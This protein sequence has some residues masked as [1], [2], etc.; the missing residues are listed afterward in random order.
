[1]VFEVAYSI[2]LMWLVSTATLDHMGVV[3]TGAAF[4]CVRV[5]IAADMYDQGCV[6]VCV[7]CWLDEL[8]VTINALLSLC[9]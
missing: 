6:C 3:G 9:A 7:R 4:S 1:V 5:P 2:F 8:F